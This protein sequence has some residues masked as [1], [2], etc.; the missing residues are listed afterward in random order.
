MDKSRH[1]HHAWV[2]ID[3][4]A[5]EHNV[6]QLKRLC[7]TE[8]MAV[9]KADAYGH[10]AEKISKI[11][12]SAGA[13]RLAVAFPQEGKALRRAGIAVPILVM[14]TYFPGQEEY[15]V[16]YRLS[17]TISS[18]E[19]LER[20]SNVARRY[21]ARVNIQIHVDT[22]MSREG[23]LI[24]D[25]PR[26]IHR[27]QNLPGIQPEGLLSHFAC[28]DVEG[29][30]EV[31]LQLHRFEQ[32]LKLAQKCGWNPHAIHIAN[33]AAFLEGVSLP[34]CNMV[35]L[36][37]SLYGLYPSL[38]VKK[39]VELKPALSFHTVVTTVKRVPEGSGVSYG[40]AYRTQKET[41]LCTLPVGYADGFSRILSGKAEV[42][43]GGRRFPVVGRICMDQCVVDVGDYPASIGEEAVLLGTQE[44][45]EITA[46]EWAEKLKTINYEV[47]CMISNRIPRIYTYKNHN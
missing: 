41:T 39:A 36:G 7:N 34:T 6:R 40:F 3:L 16:E 30:P 22:G 47:V 20:L 33:T 18:A 9:V 43:I 8:L 27:S 17:P 2:E 31:Y 21:K 5:V 44:N 11:A 26:L 14:S 10:G 4:G 28:A 45:E 15:Y 38:S 46:Q 42:L 24:Q 32:A 35:R 19:G 23:V 29:M 25:L 37:I 1:S 13:S 12:L